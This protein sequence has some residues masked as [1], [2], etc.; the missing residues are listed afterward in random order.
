MAARYLLNNSVSGNG[1]L[2]QHYQHQQQQNVLHHRYHSHTHLDQPSA[3]TH[4]TQLSITKLEGDIKGAGATCA[5][6]A[7]PREGAAAVP[8][9]MP[10]LPSPS[11]N[12]H[13]TQFSITTLEG[14]TIFPAPQGVTASVVMPP[15]PLSPAAMP[16]QWRVHVYNNHRYQQTCLN[17][18]ELKPIGYHGL[19]PSKP[20]NC[21]AA[22]AS[23]AYTVEPSA[24]LHHQYQQR[25]H[26][27]LY[28]CG[29]VDCVTFFS[30]PGH[31]Y[32]SP[33]THFSDEAICPHAGGGHVSEA[34]PASYSYCSSFPRPPP[35]AA[36]AAVVSRFSSTL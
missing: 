34:T 27:P 5:H 6:L 16:D 7:P 1:K 21:P 12:T 17:G 20:Q 4:H 15:P 9:V 36:A 2:C 22:M 24:T 18:E 33:L 26:E 11:A 10:P 30:S 23:T 13:H 31:G 19:L 3:N 32:L 29:C 28:G 14:N 35:P 25:R 8:V